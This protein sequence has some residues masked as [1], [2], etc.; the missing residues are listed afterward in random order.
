M[1]GSWVGEARECTANLLKCVTTHLGP[2]DNVPLLGDT[3]QHRTSLQ[4]RHS[5]VRIKKSRTRK[6]RARFGTNGTS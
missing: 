3:R 1:L 5:N 2:L 6:K 4:V